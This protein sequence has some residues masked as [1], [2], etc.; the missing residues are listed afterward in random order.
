MI[1]TV[2]LSCIGNEW[3]GQGG[4]C[5]E[6]ARVHRHRHTV[7]KHNQVEP[8]QERGVRPWGRVTK[9]AIK[10]VGEDRA[11][12]GVLLAAAG[13]GDSFGEALEPPDEL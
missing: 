5:G 12:A 13:V 4:G 8:K 11:R 10:Q 6:G 2:R 3:P 7:I 9:A 1:K